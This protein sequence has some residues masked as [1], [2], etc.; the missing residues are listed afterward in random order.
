MIRFPSERNREGSISGGMRRF[1]QVIDGLNLKDIPLQGGCFTWREGGGGGGGGGGL[2]IQRRARL[3]RF[4]VIEDWDAH[5]GGVEQRPVSDHFPILLEGG[6]GLVR[7]PL[8]LRFENMWIRDESFKDLIK[9][10]GGI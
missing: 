9:T 1:S 5:F 10:S 6:G 4:L 8:P 2:N 3:D 7:G